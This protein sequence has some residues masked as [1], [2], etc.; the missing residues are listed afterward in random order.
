M[1]APEGYN[2][3][4]KIGVSYKGEYAS[5]TA[6]ERLDAVYHNGSTYLALKDAPAGAPNDDGVN[7]TFLAKGFPSDIGESEIAFE[8][9]ADRTNIATGE[10]IKTVFGRIKKWFADMTAAAFAQIITSN[11]DLMATTVSGYLVDALAVKNQFAEVNSNFQSLDIQLSCAYGTINRQRIYKCG[12]LITINLN[13][14]ITTEIPPNTAFISGLPVCAVTYLGC[15]RALHHDNGASI[16]IYIGSATINTA[17]TNSMPVG[18]YG[19]N[20][21]YITN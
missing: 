8:Q 16:D 7:W 2:A 19:I 9:A 6:Y 20:I 4:G 17:A 5:N 11:T 1:A 13:L 14:S 3:L 15:A 18:I 10:S 21:S 12:K